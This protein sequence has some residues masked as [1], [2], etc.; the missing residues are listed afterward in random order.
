MNEEKKQP[1]AEQ[2]VSPTPPPTIGV[3]PQPQVIQQYVVQEKSLQGLGGM[4]IFWM[5]VFSLVAIGQIFAFA[6]ALSSGDLSGSDK[7]ITLLF[8]PLLA[9]GYIA[10]TVLI[11]LQKKL[12]IMTAFGVFGLSAL[13]SL[14]TAIVGFSAGEQETS[15]TGASGVPLLIAQILVSLLVYGLFALYFL[16]SKRVKQT[17]VN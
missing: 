12:A 6:V 1:Q 11:A 7:V 15:S 3:Q 17:L 4:L 2:P 13:Y 16:V 10:L 14:V 9:I 5:I 8:A